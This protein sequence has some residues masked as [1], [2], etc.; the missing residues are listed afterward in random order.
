[1]TY[2]DQTFDVEVELTFNSSTGQV[3]HAVFQSVDP[4]TALPPDVLTGFLPPEDGTGIGKGYLAYTVQPRAGLPTGTEI[5]NVALIC[6]DGQTIIAT[7]Q[8]DPQDPSRGIDPA[9]EALN[10]IDSG[11]PASAVAPLPAHDECHLH[12]SLAGAETMPVRS[13]LLRCSDLR[14]WRSLYQVA[15]QHHAAFRDLHRPARPY[16]S[17]LRNCDR[18]CRAY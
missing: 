13:R 4:S 14:Q 18:Q 17:L 8:I 15:E 12:G 10:T 1:M 11:S 3:L 7:N 6:F 2:N 5:R 9:K 16:V